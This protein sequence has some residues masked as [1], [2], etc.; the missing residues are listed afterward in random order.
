M[1]DM[2]LNGMMGIVKVRHVKLMS[3][4]ELMGHAIDMR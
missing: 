1:C 3:E 4:L 2:I